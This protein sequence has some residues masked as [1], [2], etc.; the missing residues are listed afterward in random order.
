MGV[1]KRG[2]WYWLDAWV[3]GHRFREP[4][5]TTDWR[6]AKRLERERIEQ[7]LNKASVPCIKP[8]L[9]RDGRPGGDRGVRAGTSSASIS[10]DVSVLARERPSLEGVLQGHHAAADH[11]CAASGVSE[12]SD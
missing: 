3:H 4:L 11:T 5:G 7:L 6:V 1:W 10:A 9:R 8:H 2:D 12:C